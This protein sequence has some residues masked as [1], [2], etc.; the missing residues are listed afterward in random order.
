MRVVF[1]LGINHQYQL[2]PDIDPPVEASTE[3]FS[4]FECFL[5]TVIE[6]YNIQGIAEEMSSYALKNGACPVIRFLIAWRR[7]LVNLIAIAIRTQ[8]CWTRNE[9]NTGLTSLLSLI[10]FRFFSF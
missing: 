7:T 2:G 3:D 9:N 4:Q 6:R 8:K 1:L 10:L 5:Q